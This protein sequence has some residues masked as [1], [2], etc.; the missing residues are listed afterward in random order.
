VTTARS[1]RDGPLAVNP[2]SSG[3]LH[4]TDTLIVCLGCPLGPANQ[5]RPVEAG[6]KFIT[7][8]SHTL[9]WLYDPTRNPD[10]GTWLAGWPSG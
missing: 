1:D 10:A 5:I 8:A 4:I 2:E 9:D 6:I 7:Q 3:Q